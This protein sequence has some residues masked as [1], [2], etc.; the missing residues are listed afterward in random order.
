[1]G[2]QRGCW[3]RLV[4]GPLDGRHHTTRA[5]KAQH[6]IVARLVGEEVGGLVG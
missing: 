1:M 6:E 2:E 4:S 5:F 3:S